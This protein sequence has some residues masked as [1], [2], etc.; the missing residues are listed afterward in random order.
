MVASPAGV[1]SITGTAWAAASSSL[2]VSGIGGTAG[3]NSDSISVILFC[4]PLRRRIAVSTVTLGL[5][6]RARSSAPNAC[7]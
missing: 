4:N 7:L 1:T 5:A 3:R 2:G 6:C